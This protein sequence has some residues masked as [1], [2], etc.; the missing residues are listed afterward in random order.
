M[1]FPFTCTHSDVFFCL[2]I[3]HS[4]EP[5]LEFGFEL[6]NVIILEQT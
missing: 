4:L 5:T 2:L 1:D 6:T 3:S